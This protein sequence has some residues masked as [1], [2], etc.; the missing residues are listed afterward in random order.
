MCGRFLLES[1]IDDIIASY[2][3]VQNISN[4]ISHSR[5]EIFPSDSVPIITQDNELKVVKWGFPFK[6]SSSGV[7]NAR[8]E[9]VSEKPFFK[10]SMDRH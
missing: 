10:K 8:A 7:I 2:E 1:D 3:Y 6:N 4:N 5:G 9:S